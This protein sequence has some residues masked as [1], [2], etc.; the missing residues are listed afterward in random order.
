MKK[1][2]NDKTKKKKPKKTREEKR[3]IAQRIAIGSI[4]AMAISWGTGAINS[5]IYN[6]DI[7]N[8]INEQEV[9][10]QEFMTSSEFTTHF[11]EGFTKISNDYTHGVITYDE[12]EARLAYLN[13]V[14]NAQN[15]LK[16]SNSGLKTE[17][18]KLDEQME[19]RRKKYSSSVINNASVS[20]LLTS[21]LSGLI[22]S[23]FVVFQN[24]ENDDTLTRD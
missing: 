3:L 10:Y 14:K 21:M 8:L 12:F 11:K 15:V 6:N 16:T 9:I 22:S 7:D 23:G 5:T 24:E 19:L 4:L 18:K 13:S 17:I 1:L 20:I 2:D